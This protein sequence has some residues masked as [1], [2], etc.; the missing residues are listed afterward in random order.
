MWA[1]RTKLKKS[2]RPCP[3]IRSAHDQPASTLI[4]P[5]HARPPCDQREHTP[6]SCRE[7]CASR[8]R[9]SEQA[10]ASAARF[11]RVPAL[12]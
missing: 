2:V 3:P 12:L 8:Q 11:P 5:C 7:P 6:R 1:R 9:P 10:C 4:A